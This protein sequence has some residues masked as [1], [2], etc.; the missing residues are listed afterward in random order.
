MSHRYA[1]IFLFLIGSGTAAMIYQ[2]IWIRL[3]TLSMGA[4]S[5]SLSIVIGAFFLGLGLGSFLSRYI[6]H[7]KRSI[8]TTYARLE[9][10]IAFS[11]LALLPVL[12]NLDYLIANVP[13]FSEI[14]ALKF[15]VITLLLLIPTTAMGATLPL[16][17]TL[18][19]QK[20]KTMGKHY[21]QVYSLNTFGAV[22]GALL[23][24]FILV[25]LIGLDGAIYTAV[26]IN[27]VIAFLAI[28]ASQKGALFSNG[29]PKMST[30][31]NSLLSKLNSSY[32]ASSHI[33]TSSPVVN[34]QKWKALGVLFIT[35]FV[36]IATEIGWSK[37]LIIFTGST[38]YGFSTLIAIL[39]FAIATGSWVIRHYLDAI[40]EPSLWLG[41]AL[42]TLSI[43]LV[44]TYSGLSYI[45]A[46]QTYL[47]HND[48]SFATQNALKYLAIFALISP[49][50]F[51]F[52]M[53]FPLALKLYTQ[54][55][56]RV[57]PDSSTAFG[58]NT[59]AGILGSM[60]AGFWLIPY[61]GTAV[62][63][64]GMAAIIAIVGAL[65]LLSLSLKKQSLIVL[66][67]SVLTLVTLILSPHLS[68][69]PLLIAYFNSQG[70]TNLTEN[71]VTYI[72]EAKSGVI[73]IIDH[74]NQYS[75]LINNGL[76]EATIDHFNQNNIDLTASLLA[77]LPYL[78]H[79]EPSP[80]K[81]G[82]IIG[83]GG[84]ISAYALTKT[85]IQSIKVVELE[86]A[87]IEAMK[88]IY[89]EGKVPALSDKRVTLEIQ[90]ARHVL[91]AQQKRYD[92]IISQPSHPWLS[93][94]S[95]LFTEEFFDIAKNRLKES[96]I[97][98]QW[99][100][101]FKMDATTLKGIIKAF[102][103]TFPYTSS[104]VIRRNEDLILIGSKQPIQ[105]TYNMVASRL[106][107][108]RIQE[109]LSQHKITKPE[110]LAPYQGLNRYQMVNMT[111]DAESSTQMNIMT[112]IHLSQLGW[113]SPTGEQ[114]PFD[115]LSTWYDTPTQ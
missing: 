67:L 36:S 26:L 39:L 55:A 45:P 110:E 80:Q 84:G 27:M 103:N 61:F 41:Y 16:I 93:G 56:E 109:I 82:F 76:S 100:N 115:L 58:V 63:L 111:Q 18:L 62:L 108:P 85:P 59:I 46:L 66:V 65:F 6:N 96:G 79:S 33:K 98:S 105:P 86:P 92:M 50:S 31:E 13:L 68:Y 81:N 60:V 5:L 21:A 71:Q 97:Y 78:L 107:E 22:L 19:I 40:K 14:P 34:Q 24:G 72:K 11:G 42:L 101:L 10:T 25:P 52:G 51:L 112:E 74:G 9:I 48:F 30:P 91:L 32:P 28:S 87:V 106:N 54:T 70:K 49:P 20:R 104:F 37:Y 12:L 64:L 3:A 29:T 94:A 113:Q 2:V 90:D 7:Q 95:N 44:Y 75:R 114:N 17:S 57:Q 23:C 88:S 99:V 47:T 102:N 69:K 73:A 8:L 38:I 4:T 53:L 83:F 43:L 77:L 15:I 35:G 89:P 1:L